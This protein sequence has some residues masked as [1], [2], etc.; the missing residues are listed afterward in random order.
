MSRQ[1][2]RQV[3]SVQVAVHA[4]IQVGCSST[5]TE[6]LA[7][8]QYGQPDAQQWAQYAAQPQQQQY[9]EQQ[10]DYS[11][12]YQQQQAQHGAPGQAQPQG[13]SQPYPPQATLD[14]QLAS[15]PTMQGNEGV[16]LTSRLYMTLL[17]IT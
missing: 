4:K 1:F 8:V 16:S 3:D 2:V 10:P 13:L 11:Y 5:W 7:P 9:A 14:P 6:T 17:M 15:L 12:Y